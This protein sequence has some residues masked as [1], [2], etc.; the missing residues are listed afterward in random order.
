MAEKSIIM[1]LSVKPEMQDLLKVSAKKAGWSVSELVR[2]LIQRHLSLV[3]ND[4][5]DIPVIL[6]IPTALRGDPEKLSAWLKSR[7]DK[8]ISSLS[9]PA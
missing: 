7:T 8:I 5:N 2:A 1:S 3:V 4:G 9:K 6:R